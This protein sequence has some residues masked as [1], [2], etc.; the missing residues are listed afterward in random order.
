M[1][2]EH[3][4]DQFLRLHSMTSDADRADL[5]AEIAV[6][7]VVFDG[8]EVF[9]QG[10][11][12]ILA[13]FR[14]AEELVR[15]SAVQVRGRWLRWSW[16]GRVGGTVVRRDDGAPYSGVAVARKSDDGRLEMVVPFLGLVSGPD[17]RSD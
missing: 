9:A 7:D 12:E 13:A 5:L 14:G 15:T 17:P 6:S 1:T 4:V 3:T 8:I 16:E 2:P 10:H 11:A